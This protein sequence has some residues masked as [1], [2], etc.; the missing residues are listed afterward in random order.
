MRLLDAG[1]LGRWWLA[2]CTNGQ[3]T[4]SQPTFTDADAPAC[5]V[6]IGDIIDGKYKIDNH[7]AF[8]GMGVVCA[9]THLQLET[10]V[11]I[12][13]VRSELVQNEDAV[14]RFLN[15]A[16]AAAAL[17][18]EHVAHVVD[19]GRL[20]TGAP[21]MVMEYLE[22]S[23]LWSTVAN[24]GP[25][26]IAT[27]VDYALQACEALAEAH[28]AHIIHRDIKPENLFLTERPDGNYS[29]KVLDFGVSKQLE[30]ARV[31]GLTR[32]GSGIGSPY[33][34]SPE[35]MCSPATVDVRTDIWSVGC[36][37]YVL[38]T[39]QLPFYSESVATICTKV[40]N[41]RPTPIRALRREVPAGLEAVV[42]RCL[43]KDRAGRFADVGELVRALERFAS[44]DGQAHV[45]RVERILARGNEPSP[46]AASNPS[47]VGIVRT[48][49]AAV[50]LVDPLG[51]T[52]AASAAG[53]RK[54][55]S[56]L[57]AAVAALLVTG[58]ALAAHY[59][60]ILPTSRIEHYL[61][62]SR[63]ASY[64]FPVLAPTDPELETAWAA[65]SLPF[66]ASLVHAI[67]KQTAQGNSL[68]IGRAAAA[69]KPAEPNASP[70]EAIPA[71]VRFP[72]APMLNPN[73]ASKHKRSAA[74]SRAWEKWR[75]DREQAAT[76]YR[77]YLSSLR[78]SSEP[79]QPAVSPEVPSEIVADPDSPRE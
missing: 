55:R 9:A 31:V 14:T 24:G 72:T 2:P 43:Q 33:Y 57:V 10:Q 79:D 60:G 41:E 62:S 56:M 29:I 3:Q 23:D 50:P 52:L 42:L 78:P 32:P 25:L 16:K 58:C 71:A 38:F 76:E 21:Y 36:V 26:P 54:G 1:A 11:A 63:L 17:K 61:L 44:R 22:G 37:L 19:Y 30:N 48:P 28:A 73:D 46:R 64:A 75:S 27:A 69:T 45:A 53:V 7:L 47:L 39:G 15:E 77:G 13:F 35:Q 67:G 74:E 40:L 18:G 51:M 20:P 59:Q 12:K 68:E 49:I 65:R 34:M 6:A 70:S 4:M 5:P 66:E 8:G